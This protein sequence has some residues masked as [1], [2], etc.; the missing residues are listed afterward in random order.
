MPSYPRV[1]LVTIEEEA[2]ESKGSKGERYGTEKM[3]TTEIIRRRKK[4]TKSII[5]SFSDIREQ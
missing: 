3:D 1:E 5:R 4:N 2:G